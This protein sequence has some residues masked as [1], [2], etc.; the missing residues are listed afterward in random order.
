LEFQ[1][2]E[3]FVEASIRPWRFHKFLV[4]TTILFRVP[5]RPS[6]RIAFI[7]NFSFS[8]SNTTMS[9]HDEIIS[10]FTSMTGCDTERAQFYLESS[11]WDIGPALETYFDSGA[12]DAADVG[13]DED[14]I[15]PGPRQPHGQ[16]GLARPTGDSKSQAPPVVNPPS[17]S[18]RIA[19]FSSIRKPESEDDSDEERDKDD[20]QEFYVGSGQE[21]LGPGRKRNPDELISSIFKSARQHGAEQV[22]E[23]STQPV[24]RTG[25][26]RSFGGSGTRLGDSSGSGAPNAAVLPPVEGTPAESHNP[27]V[28]LRMWRNG[29]TINDGQVRLYADP[30]NHQFMESVKQ[31]RVPPELLMAAK[32]RELRV[33]MEDKRDQEFQAPKRQA[34]YFGGAGHMLGR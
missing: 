11:N 29:F 31:G 23:S 28:T 6:A 9:D 32:G 10:Q 17:S 16:V 26:P 20:E 3:D 21:V 18:A 14:D 12:H 25:Q 30:A 27:I 13:M 33:Q 7:D 1:L 8:T 4:D 19:T 34:E 15:P 22:D 24:L 2:I 5:G